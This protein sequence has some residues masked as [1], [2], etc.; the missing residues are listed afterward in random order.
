MPESDYQYSPASQIVAHTESPLNKMT[1]DSRQT[2]SFRS[3]KSQEIIPQFAEK[4]R[5]QAKMLQELE[6]YKL[7]CEKR[8]LELCPEHS[9]PVKKSDLG[10]S[11]FII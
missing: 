1:I 9:L 5:I 3:N 4:I 8:I 11:F 2:E 10:Q 6:E 7:L